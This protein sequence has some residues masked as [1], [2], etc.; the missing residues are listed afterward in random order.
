MQHGSAPAPPEAAAAAP[1][2]S[3]AETV[4]YVERASVVV[5][6]AGVGSFLVA[7]RAGHVPVMV[8]RLRR[9][10]EHVDDHQ[11]QFARALEEQ[12]DAI[13]VLDVA[14]LPGAVRA[15][16]PRR[17]VAA[18]RPGPL[19]AAV[20]RALDGEPLGSAAPRRERYA[21][22]RRSATT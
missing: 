8:P 12:G 10:G 13:A 9:L 17:P 2:L 18:A 1:Y 7:R 11:V 15:V 20:R 14:G 21:A 4:A 6:H 16:P 19:P 5:T 22:G 3:F